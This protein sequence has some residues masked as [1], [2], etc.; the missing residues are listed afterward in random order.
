VFLGLK[1]WLISRLVPER[2]LLLVNYETLSRD[3]GVE[4]L[5]L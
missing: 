3:L 4:S 5:D 1:D 2:A